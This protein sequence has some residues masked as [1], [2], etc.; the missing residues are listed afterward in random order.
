M[1]Y[2]EMWEKVADRKIFIIIIMI[3]AVATYA[4]LA[5]LRETPPLEVKKTLLINE[6]KELKE[7]KRYSFFSNP[8]L[9]SFSDYPAVN[10]SSLILIFNEPQYKSALQEHF[11]GDISQEELEVML[12]SLNLVGKDEWEYLYL[13]FN[14]ENEQNAHKFA[15]YASKVFLDNVKNNNLKKI[16]PLKEQYSALLANEYEQLRTIKDNNAAEY[17]VIQKNI[18]YFSAKA[19]E[20]SAYEVF[21]GNALIAVDQP[22]ITII[23]TNLTS[24]YI[25]VI[26]A[27]LSLILAVLLILYGDLR[28]RGLLPR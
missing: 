3:V 24:L 23:N 7:T 25:Y 10:Y 14:A 4:F 21:A 19:R 6:Y 2:K 12:N 1:S 22:E 8:L 5:N 11:S 15:D 13:D 9:G 16:K 28:Q 26:I 20:I 27:L 18:E 17:S